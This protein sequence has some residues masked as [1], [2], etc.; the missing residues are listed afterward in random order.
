L[1]DKISYK[2][3]L[4][5]QNQV[6]KKV[7]NNNLPGILIL[8]QHNPVIT[9]GRAGG[10]E[11]LRVSLEEYKRLGIEIHETN[12]GGNVTYHRPGQRVG[13]PILNLSYWKK[14]LHWYLRSIEQVIINTLQSYGLKKVGRKQKYTGVW[15][16]DKKIAAIGIAVKN[17]ITMHGFA[18]QITKE[19]MDHFKLINPCG[20]TE[21]GVVSLEE[22]LNKVNF[23]KVVR[24]IKN[25]FKKVFECTLE[26]L[27]VSDAGS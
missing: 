9:I 25:N 15:V 2:E 10:W 11:N 22:L 1:K 18:F 26:K 4:E 13:Y 3:G 7:K 19:K 27:E 23:N 16:G 5:L 14:D 24:D 20:I 17:W 21:F 8:Q 12:R 6:F